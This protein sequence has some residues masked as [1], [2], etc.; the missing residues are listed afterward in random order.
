MSRR[1]FIKSTLNLRTLIDSEVPMRIGGVHCSNAN[2]LR[3]FRVLSR[4]LMRETRT[5]AV[6]AM[7]Y[8]T[9]MVGSQSTNYTGPKEKIDDGFF[10]VPAVVFEHASLHVHY[11][12]R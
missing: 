1:K 12:V 7:A 10:L 11:A 8:N 9:T 6:N 2:F 4:L 5:S 3:K